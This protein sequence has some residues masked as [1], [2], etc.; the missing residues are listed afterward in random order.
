[1]IASLL[2]LGENGFLF[3][4]VRRWVPLVGIARY[5]IKFLL[6]LGFAVPLM[7]GFAIRRLEGAA[8]ERGSWAGSFAVVF[9]TTALCIVAIL[10]AARVDHFQYDQWPATLH[11]GLVRLLFLSMTV[12]GLVFFARSANPKMKTTI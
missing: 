9:G 11:N 1:L 12:A 4:L 10:F 7:A 2:A 5:P 6:L 3:P 8:E